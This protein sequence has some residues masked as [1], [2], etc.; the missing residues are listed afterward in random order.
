MISKKVL[1]AKIP[2]FRNLKVI[3]NNRQGTN[4]IVDEILNTYYECEVDYDEIYEYFD[5]IDIYNT[6]EGLWNFMRYNFNYDAE[7]ENSQTVR[8]PTA[9]LQ[10]GAKVDCKHF[11]SF[12]G[13]VLGAIKRNEGDD[14]DWCFRFVCYGKSPDVDH[15]FV[16]VFDGNKEIWIDPCLSEFD[17]HKEPTH[18]IDEIPIM[19][20]YKISGVKDDKPFIIDEIDPFVANR[21]FINATNRNL[22]GLRDLFR[23]H[24]DIV[25]GPVRKYFIANGLSWDVFKTVIDG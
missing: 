10:D 19:P 21:S 25:N 18:I 16:V 2:P 17:Y 1:L 20:I 8:T 5:K 7:H 12:I 13:G 3:I 22:Y 11:A 15:V 14:W 4:E 6:C 24:P 9:I 23:S